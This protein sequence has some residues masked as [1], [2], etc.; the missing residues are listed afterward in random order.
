MACT[1][2][3]ALARGSL[4]LIISALYACQRAPTTADYFPFAVGTSWQYRVLRSTMDGSREQRYAVA[5]VAATSSDDPTVRIR[6]TLDGQRYYYRVADAGILRIGTRRRRGNRMVI[7]DESPQLVLPAQ[8]AADVS[9]HAPTMTSV[10]ENSGAPWDS[11]F[12]VTVPVA[13][14]YRVESLVA[15]VE[16]PAG[17]FRHCLIIAGA[18]STAVDVGSNLG[19]TTITI[20]TREWYAAGVGLVRLERHEQTSAKQLAEGRLVMELDSWHQR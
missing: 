9:W 10:L 18:G 8:L 4:A 20:S 5:N 19:H 17:R 14:Q 16:T 6:E 7:E 1:I 12:R 2:V 11:T 15:E 3:R 13:M